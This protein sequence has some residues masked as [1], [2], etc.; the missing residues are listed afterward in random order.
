MSKTRAER[1]EAFERWADRVA[2]EELRDADPDI[3]RAIIES[4]E[5]QAGVDEAIAAARGSQAS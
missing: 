3:A 2:P 1:L 4:L 5:N